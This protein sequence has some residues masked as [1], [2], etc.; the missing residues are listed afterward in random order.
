LDYCLQHR[1]KLANYFSD[2]LSKFPGLTPAYVAEGC[3][4][5]Y[6][7]YPI[8]FD[9]NAV[10]VS[11][12]TFIKAVA[13]EFP[14]P[15]IWEQN[16][17]AG[18]YV[19]P[20]YWSPMYQTQTAIGKKGFPWSMNPSVKYNYSKGICPVVERMHEKEMIHSPMIRENVTESDLNDVISAIE[21]VYENIG[22]LKGL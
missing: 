14:K 4:H 19:A 5:A 17:M 20:L 12:S 6:Y 16:V 21:K 11:R 2:K 1:K 13:A 3:G 18:G 7:Q 10:G 22:E 9:E 8:K 15:D